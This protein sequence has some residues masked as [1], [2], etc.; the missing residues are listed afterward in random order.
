[1]NQAA[2]FKQLQI[3]KQDSSLPNLESK[4]LLKICLIHQ[5]VTFKCYFGQKSCPPPLGAMRSTSHCAESMAKPNK[6]GSIKV[7]PSLR[8]RNTFMTLVV[9]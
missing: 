4:Y 5:R 7:A 8:H 9:N 3:Y 6:Q 1:M 2:E